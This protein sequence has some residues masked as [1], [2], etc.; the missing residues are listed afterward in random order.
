MVYRK[1]YCVLFGFQVS[2]SGV[3]DVT[4]AFISLT[5]VNIP[6][7]EGQLTRRINFTKSIVL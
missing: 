6:C 4:K 5:D 2:L 3:N 1:K 7:K